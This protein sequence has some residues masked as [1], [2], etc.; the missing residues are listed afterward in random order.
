MND[1]CERGE[2]VSSST[3]EDEIER[4]GVRAVGRRRGASEGHLG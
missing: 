3:G 2:A 1:L 4:D